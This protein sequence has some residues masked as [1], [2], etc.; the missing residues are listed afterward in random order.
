MM[1][2]EIERREYIPVI[3][4]LTDGLDQEVRITQRLTFLILQSNYMI[5]GTTYL[6]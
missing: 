3:K 6:S 4:S 2:M 1:T 5:V